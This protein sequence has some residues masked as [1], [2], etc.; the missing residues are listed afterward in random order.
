MNIIIMAD[1]KSKPEHND[2]IGAD[3]EGFG[4]VHRHFVP[5]E[6]GVPLLHR[7]AAQFDPWGDVTLVCNGTQPYLDVPL[8]SWWK[9]KRSPGLRDLD[10]LYKT[11]PLW[12]DA[13][14]TVLLYGDVWFTDEAVHTIGHTDHRGISIFGRYGP[15]S[16]GLS[17]WG[18]QFAVSF[19]PEDR[20]RIVQACKGLADL[21]GKGAI[22]RLTV[23]ELQQ[24]IDHFRPGPHRVGASW[25]EIDD[26]TDDIDYEDDYRNHLT[27]RGMV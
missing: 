1:G 13:E 20:G 22:E 15:S 17:P 2:F 14:R 6:D 7:T 8:T 25:V 5:T 3:L 23:W 10:M 18:E 26:L 11:H 21:Y 27:G 16:F 19:Y 12:D 9:P 24:V 4:G